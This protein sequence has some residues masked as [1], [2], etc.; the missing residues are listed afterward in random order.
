MRPRHATESD[1]EARTPEIIICEHDLTEESWRPRDGFGIYAA[2]F[3]NN[4]VNDPSTHWPAPTE[5]VAEQFR[6]LLRLASSRHRACNLIVTPEASL[7]SSTVADGIEFLTQHSK[8]RSTAIVMGLQ[9]MSVGACSTMVDELGISDSE[10]LH[11]LLDGHEVDRP[12]NATLILVSSRKGAVRAFLQPKLNQSA[13]EHNPYHPANLLRGRQIYVFQL[14]GWSFCALTCSDFF[15]L[16]P[17]G[18]ERILDIVERELVR[19]RNRSDGLDLLVNHQY[20]RSPDHERFLRGYRRLYGDEIH[21]RGL[22][23]L[24]VNAYAPDVGIR[25][26]TRLVFHGDHRIP[27]AQPLRQVDAP[28]EGFEVRDNVCVAWFGLDRLPKSWTPDE[29]AHVEFEIFEFEEDRWV[30]R[31]LRATRVVQRPPQIP[32][33]YENYMDFAERLSVLGQFDDAQGWAESARDRALSMHPKRYLTAAQHKIFVAQQFRH[34]GRYREALAAYGVASGDLGQVSESS[35][36]LRLTQFR[37]RAGQIMVEDFLTAGLWRR[38]LEAYLGLDDEL[39]EY[40]ANSSLADEER[41]RFDLYRLHLRRQ[42]AEMHRVGGDDL[43]VALRLY[44]EVFDEYAW[45]HAREKAYAALG[46]GDCLR[47][48]CDL[49]GAR[50]YYRL[51]MAYA[52]DAGERRLEARVLR[53]ECELARLAHALTDPS[54]GTSP[55]ADDSMSRLAALSARVDYRYGRVYYALTRNGWLLNTD[56]ESALAGFRSVRDEVTGNGYELRLEAAYAWL[57]MAEAVR[58]GGATS[59]ADESMEVMLSQAE[60]RFDRMGMTWGLR[61]CEIG[62]ARVMDPSLAAG[63]LPGLAVTADGGLASTTTFAN[64]P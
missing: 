60:R 18:E 42:C 21:A 23:T 4:M 50:E 29:T 33:E 57:G 22:A 32:V 43:E 49:G 7:P 61:R 52:Q 54:G 31:G 38:A 15:S 5:H 25:G 26:G 40:L 19:T 48:L 17:N 6:S 46:I 1:S 30:D 53:N 36:L 51:S 20:N 35:S 34:Q 56:P 64:L 3:E 44:R 24:S 14:D 58:L 27:D 55:D 28:V 12:V 39:K 9:F 41:D 10:A 45:I 8:E 37:H 62:R 2:Q 11:S 16:S 47:L 63:P 13:D 59:S